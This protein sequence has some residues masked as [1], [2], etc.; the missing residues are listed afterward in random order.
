MEDN[1]SRV[2][3]VLF[4]QHKRMPGPEQ[5]NSKGQPYWNKLKFHVG[6][7]FDDSVNVGT[8]SDE[9]LEESFTIPR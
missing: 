6:C 4:W 3:Q 1:Y 9:E 2:E 7:I 5:S 8:Y